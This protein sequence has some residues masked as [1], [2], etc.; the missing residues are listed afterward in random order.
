M[1]ALFCCLSCVYMSPFVFPLQYVSEVVIG[2]PYAV[3]KDLM[4]HFK[5]CVHISIAIFI[6]FRFNPLQCF[7]GSEGHVALDRNPEAGYCMSP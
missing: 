1:T 2:A 6:W 7:F 5:V 4:D 3:T